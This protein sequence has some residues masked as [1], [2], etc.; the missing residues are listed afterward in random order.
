DREADDR[1]D[2]RPGVG[3]TAACNG[4]LS[5]DRD[6][7]RGRDAL[8]QLLYRRINRAPEIALPQYRPDTAKNV[9]GGSIV[10][11]RLEAISDLDAILVIVH[12]EEQQDSFVATLLADTP[13]LKQ[14]NCCLF[15][16]VAFKRLHQYDRELRARRAFD[17]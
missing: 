11:D 16:L 8:A 1:S 17:V 2:V 6:I 9:S 10:D 5:F 14:P 13:L 3:R 7:F 15:D 4:P 12:C